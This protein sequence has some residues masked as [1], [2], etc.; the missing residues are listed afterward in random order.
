MFVLVHLLTGVVI[1][2]TLTLFFRDRFVIIMAIVGSV[3]PDLID[4]PLGHIFLAETIGY[5]RIYG[6]TLL[7][8]SVLLI[9]GSIVSY[10]Y[11][12]MG[13]LILATIAG[14]LSHQ[15]LDF[16]WAE[17]ANW[18]WPVFGLFKGNV[19]TGFLVNAVF[20]ELSNPYEWTAGILVLFLLVQTGV[21]LLPGLAPY[22][23]YAAGAGILFGVISL[24]SGIFVQ[25][26]LLTIPA[27][28]S[29]TLIASPIII[30]GA[31]ILWWQWPGHLPPKEG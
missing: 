8:I 2:I 16:M 3:L 14:I 24:I 19:P 26:S 12:R 29:E 6:H 11:R 18:C 23:R 15:L 13:P 5:G 31:S 21:I 27:S 22:R 9:A 25:F 10:R 17:P 28:P 4:K 30:A 20:A 1:G 7:F